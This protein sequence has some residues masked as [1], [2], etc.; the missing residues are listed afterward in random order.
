MDDRMAVEAVTAARQLLHDFK[1]ARSDWENDKTPVDTVV[2]WYGLE[3]A[4]FN[5]DDQPQGTYG[6]LEP[7]ENL[8][9][10]CRDL[11]ETL[12][13]FTLAH[14]LGHAVLH[15]SRDE[16]Q[17]V[18]EPS[19]DDPC[20]D[21][22]VQ[23][24]VT[25]LVE[26]EQF[27]E[28]LGIGQVY[29]PRSQRELAANIFAAEL[30]MPLERV[31][32]LYLERQVEPQALAGTFG[33]STS[34]ML[35]RLAG[36]MMGDHQALHTGRDKSGT[37]DDGELEG[38]AEDT[39]TGGNQERLPTDGE[40]GPQHDGDGGAS[41]RKEY[42]EFQ[43]A[44]IEAATPA[45]IVAG[46][47]S[48]KTSTLIGRAEYLIRTLDVP[49]QHILA[50]TF[51]RKA[52]GEM[53]ERLQ[54][55][56]QGTPAQ[57]TPPMV[58]TFHAFCAELL[59]THGE[60]VGLRSDFSLVDDA[61]GY[62]LL[63]EL[64]RELPLRYYQHLQFPTFYFPDILQAIS[65][66]KDELA[67]PEHYRWLAQQMLE[68]AQ[69]DEGVQAA[70]KALEVADIYACYQAGLQRRG[71]TDFGGL[72]MLATQLLQEYPEVIREQQEGYQHILVDEFQDMNRASG[73]LLRLLAGEQRRV[74]VVGDA[75]QAIY[76]FRGAS[77]ANIANFQEDYPGAAVLPLNRNYRS[78][79][80]IVNLADAF[81]E[82]AMELGAE[83]GTRQVARPT[84]PDSYV[85]LGVAADEASELE[86][87]IADMRCKQAQHGYSYGDMVVLCR[88]RALARKVSQALARA[89]LP[90]I[91]RG[92]GSLVEQE[93]I[94][95]ALSVVLLLADPG[96]MGILR[97][98]RRSEHAITQEDVE[99]LLL[100]AREQ[101]CSPGSLI[102]RGEAPATMSSQGRRSL[103]RLASM[104]QALRHL[105]DVWSMLAQYV[106]V[107]TS[108][109]RDLLRMAVY[110]ETDN[111]REQARRVL[112]DYAGLLQLA[113]RYDQRRQ[114][115]GQE[116]DTASMS[117]QA[118]GFLDYLSVM[119]SLRQ[120]GGQRREGAED[121]GD[122]P[123]GIRVMTVHASK[124]LEFPVVYLPGLAQR[125]FPMQGRSSS[126][127]PPVGMLPLEG[128]D[129]SARDIAESGEAC[130]FYVGVTRARDQ[131]IL[132]YSERYGKQNYKA[133]PYLDALAA[134]LS[135]ARLVKVYWQ[136]E[137]TAAVAEETGEHGSTEATEFGAAPAVQ[138]STTPYQP[139]KG[140]IAAME[141]GVLSASAIETYQTCP[142]RY[143]YGHIY[144]FRR[145][146]NDYQLFWQATRK[147]LE[148]LQTSLA[149]VKPAREEEGED[150]EARFP[151]REEFQ[152]L[153]AQHWQAVGGHE[154]PF[155]P[156]Y[157]R[158]GREIIGSLW[159]MLAGRERVTWELQRGFEV[160]VGGRT[161]RVEVDR[162]EAPAQTGRPAR[163]VRTRISKSK[164]K[165]TAEVRELLYAHAY[166]QQ[167]PGQSIELHHHNLSTGEMLS[168]TLT[169]KRQRRL[170]EELA[171]TIRGLEQ[172]AYPATPDS[173]IC[174]SCPFFLIC[175]A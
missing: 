60:R 161:I 72:I 23:E 174:P 4:T 122:G 33:V 1:E 125:R 156:I 132:S 28:I 169:E 135:G 87:L 54:Q 3:V 138:G 162:V 86:G 65:R 107:E 32:S 159:S 95:D 137:T 153:Y 124:G 80:D 121:A 66:A 22:D 129:Q 166:R 136:G 127:S 96:G 10:L 84:Q 2:T 158:H 35:N 116:R 143:A 13:R 150:Q 90:V 133:S 78:R 61:E 104:L 175:P 92:G 110:A 53:Q 113:R 120:D 34:A 50:L 76:S 69:D 47:G 170:L 62:F 112:A 160:E 126:T 105:P 118:K 97:A 46:P 39:H 146:E 117:E 24:A 77:P 5:P 119:A 37:H 41:S 42:D 19:P 139:S 25:G 101:R 58:S 83:Q 21:S 114:E 109:V 68:W 55:A 57:D 108:A 106:L 100:A 91:E 102:V 167:Y 7:G 134:G 31:A 49:A 18:L 26:Q 111:Q 147:T 79:P 9:W 128:A 98:A 130:L 40:E 141:S 89:G 48:G 171:H 74:W 172:H 45:L 81:R 20:Q 15:R 70:E 11:P 123:V 151:T 85:T 154:S 64:A 131:L 148:A 51:S 88:T 38:D 164:G 163:F 8:I 27:E 173:F 30:L 71:D 168:I 73:V 43:Q 16:Q 157:E 56:L 155:A 63:R 144:R 94:R 93:H 52:A 165:T 152:D 75:N 29:N 149:E 99:A 59:R 142:R 82:R 17:Q 44:A 103:L 115:D 140:F 67:A 12:R 145:E 14:E 6:W 36:L